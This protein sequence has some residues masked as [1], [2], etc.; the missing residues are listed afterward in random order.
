MS[1]FNW[2]L[3]IVVLALSCLS[4]G[5]AMALTLIKDGKSE[6]AIIVPDKAPPSVL[7]AAAEL[8]RDLAL[9]TGAE[10]S[11][12]KDTE[13]T[14]GPVISLGSTRQAKSAGVSIDAVP[15]S[16]F[17]ILTRG[18][19]LYIIGLDTAAKVTTTSN[20]RNYN[21]LEPQPGVA[22]PQFTKNGG[23]SN[24]T[25]N[26]VY[27]FLEDY[28]DVRW[29]MPGDLGR[30]VPP[31]PDKTF[32]IDDLDRTESPLFIFRSL[33]YSQRTRAVAQWWDFQKL[34]FSFRNSAGHHWTQTVAASLYD[35][36]PDWFAMINGKRPRP[37]GRYKLET[38]NPQLIRYYAEKAIAELKADPATN[39]YSLSPS[40][41]RGWSQSPQSKA[42]YDPPAPGEDVPSMSRLIF[43]FYR[44]VSEIVAREYPQG[45]LTGY[46]YADYRLPPTQWSG[47]FP[48]NFIPV[49]APGLTAG[50]MLYR[51]EVR[52][53]YEKL[54]S[55]WARIMPKTWFSYDLTTWLEDSSGMLTPAA[56]ELLNTVFHGFVEYHVKGELAYGVPAWS[57]A[58]LA[59][60]IKAKLLWNPR[61]DAV[62]I[63]R[64]WLQRAYGPK[65]GAA[66]ERL[67]EQLGQWFK[68]GWR[69]PDLGLKYRPTETLFKSVY[70]PH[71]AELEQLFLN[72][73][74]QPMTGI[75]KRRL[76]LIEDN[77]VVLQWRLRNAGYLPAGFTSPLQ[78]GDAAVADLIVKKHAEF[79]HFPGALTSPRLKPVKV[80]SGPPP[81]AAPAKSALPNRR[82]I[83]F[84][85]TRGGPVQITF[86]NVHS[87]SAFLSYQITSAQTAR[88]AQSGI[89]YSDESITFAAE[90]NNAYYLS[91]IPSGVTQ[92]QAT[93][94]ISFKDA[95]PAEAHFQNDVLYLN[96]Q[97]SSALLRVY[98]PPG[99][100]V[101]VQPG[102]SG[103]AL[104]IQNI[105]RPRDFPNAQVVQ[106]LDDAWR[107]NTDPDKSGLKRGFA[108]PDFND[109]G[110]KNLTATDWWQN[111]GF[112]DYHGA[113]W[114]RKAFTLSDKQAGHKYLLFFGAV[115]GDA[116][117]YLNGQK[118]GEHRLGDDGDG[119]DEPFVFY[120]T[121]ALQAGRN[122]IAVQVTKNA[123]MSGIYK[124][125]SLLSQAPKPRK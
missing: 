31:R 101:S 89:V 49:I 88:P 87:G 3:L 106:K 81:A 110:W 39:T 17:R 67:Y 79:D 33:P 45:R 21:N 99:L 95:A 76:G 114:Y 116:V 6:Y 32:T 23:F 24:G 30:D 13:T 125:V 38:T 69:N 123:H 83:L 118:I 60:Y 111:Q 25:A 78:R 85:S 42:L 40:D 115:D 43:K 53:G 12:H 59:N 44:D 91:I 26:G 86:F 55:G 20:V 121:S 41:S 108:Q 97:T 62:A 35:Q 14:S 4:A 29:L 18:G 61:L 58:S 68:E 64:Q 10:L 1:R 22:G 36:H 92:A 56:P 52:Q 46:I 96:S 84:Y 104:Q 98:T 102:T 9:A 34:G 75:Q 73:A 80:Q 37:T 27:T 63:Q 109:A 7:N 117:V 119:W 120:V 51:D 19:D 8:K 103:A 124:G 93:W 112:A 90:A 82:D 72:A 57:Q 15:A 48:D 107:F 2:K 71:Y 70:A 54:M 65:A 94:G 100:F 5:R 11:I 113:A 77:L 105:Q 16:G 47:E 50:Y 74:A 66:M 28:L 122:T